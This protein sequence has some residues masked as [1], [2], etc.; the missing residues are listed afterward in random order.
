MDKPFLLTCGENYYPCS[1]DGDWIGFFSTKEE[2]EEHFLNIQ[3]ELPDWNKFDWHY[4]IDIRK[5][6]E[7]E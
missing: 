4:V 5:W 6:L 1:S 3:K 2:A 7:K